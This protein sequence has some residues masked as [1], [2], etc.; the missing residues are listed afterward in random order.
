[1]F[2]NKFKDLIKKVLN[3]YIIYIFYLD[4]QSSKITNRNDIMCNE[5]VT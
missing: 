4:Y 5:L 1:M 2:K 3:I